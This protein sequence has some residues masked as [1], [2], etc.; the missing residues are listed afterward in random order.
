MDPGIP[1]WLGVPWNDTLR[2]RAH[3]RQL[4]EILAIDFWF[5]IMQHMVFLLTENTVWSA[6]SCHNQAQWWDLSLHLI[7]PF[8][9]FLSNL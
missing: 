1:G 3:Y 8:S 9:S 7:P 5:V 4:L 6:S 2:L